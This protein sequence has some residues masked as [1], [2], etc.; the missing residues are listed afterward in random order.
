MIEALDLDLLVDIALFGPISINDIPPQQIDI[1]NEY[2]QQNILT[3]TD[4]SYSITDYGIEEV[5]KKHDVNENKK[6]IY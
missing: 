5:R 2:V 1:Y 6:R 4:G 3:K